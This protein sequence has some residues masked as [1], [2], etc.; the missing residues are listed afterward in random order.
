MD[1]SSFKTDI[2]ANKLLEE[3]TK[4]SVVSSWHRSPTHSI[5]LLHG[6]QYVSFLFLY[7]GLN[8]TDSIEHGGGCA[9]SGLFATS[10][11]PLAGA[12]SCLPLEEIGTFMLAL[13]FPSL[14]ATTVVMSNELVPDVKAVLATASLNGLSHT[15]SLFLSYRRRTTTLSKKIN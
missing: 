4:L 10:I 15:F 2:V 12:V 13:F 9:T 14:S 1:T 8:V 7:M 5:H 6:V 11:A 3:L